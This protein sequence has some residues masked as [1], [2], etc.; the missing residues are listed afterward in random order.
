MSTMVIPT[1]YRYTRTQPLVEKIA[2]N[3]TNNW[4]YFTSMYPCWVECLTSSNLSSRFYFCFRYGPAVAQ[5]T[6]NSMGAAGLVLQVNRHK[7][8]SINLS[9]FHDCGGD[10]RQFGEDAE[11]LSS[12]YF[13][14]NQNTQLTARRLTSSHS[15]SSLNLRNEVA[16]WILNVTSLST[17]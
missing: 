4:D 5:A 15:W 2:K 11:K 14:T 16:R 6:N 7:I 3:L 1:L 13:I 12:V 10:W 17:N 9:P 8:I